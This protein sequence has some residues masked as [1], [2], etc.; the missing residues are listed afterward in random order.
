MSQYLI[1]SHEHRAWWRAERLGYTP[2]IG[3]AGA[4]TFAEAAEIVLPHIPPGEEVAVMLTPRL[5]AAREARAALDVEPHYGAVS[6][7]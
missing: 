3:E 2:H 5:D 1:W 4:Y 7:S 6:V